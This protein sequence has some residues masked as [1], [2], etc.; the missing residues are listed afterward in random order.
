MCC[1]FYMAPRLI[2]F[3][4]TETL[5]HV[6]AEVRLWEQCIHLLLS[7]QHPPHHS[8]ETTGPLR[9][10]RRVT[11]TVAKKLDLFSLGWTH[12]GF[13]KNFVSNIF[14]TFKNAV[15]QKK[16]PSPKTRTSQPT[17]EF[18]LF[19]FFVY[20]AIWLKTVRTI[21]RTKVRHARQEW[22]EDGSWCQW[23]TAHCPE[24][25]GCEIGRTG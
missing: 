8:Q 19:C 20:A 25:D 3:Y 18:L 24:I 21:F 23:P 1:C 13:R 17:E 5:G 4:C 12:G 9:S 22:L 7:N 2:R 14:L 11:G 10:V 15:K 6:Q 16:S